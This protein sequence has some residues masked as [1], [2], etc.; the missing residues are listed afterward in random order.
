MLVTETSEVEPDL[1]S[2]Q[3]LSPPESKP[4]PTASLSAADPFSARHIGP[5]PAEAKQMLSLLGF[6][7]L[8]D[9]IDAAVP[10]GIRLTEPLRIPPGRSE[11]ETLT[12]LREIAGQNQVFKSFIGMGYSDCV[13]PPVI[14]RA[15]F[16][17]PGWYTQY[18]PY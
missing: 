10:R 8:D 5:S 2:T 3:H 6:S 7:K 13:T 15:L 9:L 1:T 4:R 14:Q 17:N 16:E 12:A 11:M 18:T